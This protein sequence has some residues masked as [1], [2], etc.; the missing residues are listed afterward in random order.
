MLSHFSHVRLCNPTDCSPPGSSVHG[1]PGNAGMGCHFLLQQVFP[2]WDQAHSFCHS[3]CFLHWQAGPL[4]P[5]PPG[6]AL[7]GGCSKRGP[8]RPSGSGKTSTA[9]PGL[10]GLNGPR[11]PS[12]GTTGRGELGDLGTEERPSGGPAAAGEALP[13]GSPGRA[14]CR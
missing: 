1:I 3:F 4:P 7:G 14:S 9:H 11:C 10:V 12:M 2:T 13:S 5:A 8:V 6:D